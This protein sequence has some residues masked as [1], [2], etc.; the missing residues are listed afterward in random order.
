MNSSLSLTQLCFTF[1]LPL[2]MNSMACCLQ[3]RFIWLVE[4]KQCRPLPLCLFRL[5]LCN[6]RHRFFLLFHMLLLFKISHC[7][8][9]TPTKGIITGTIIVATI[10]AII[11]G[12]TIVEI[13]KVL[14]PI[15]RVHLLKL[16]PKFFVKFMA[17][18]VMKQS[19]AL[20]E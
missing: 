2:L 11:G 7:R 19:I 10:K 8:I 6:L 15:N 20:I 16:V 9:I 4:S 17:P 1:H 18:L 12:T 13:I 3:K 5:S 14:A